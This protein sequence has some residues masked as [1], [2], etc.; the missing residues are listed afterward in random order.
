MCWVI[1]SISALASIGFEPS[2]ATQ[3]ACNDRGCAGRLKK[4]PS[5]HS[6]RVLDVIWT[7]NWSKRTLFNLVFCQTFLIYIR[8]L[9]KTFVW[10]QRDFLGKKTNS[11]LRVFCCI[12][13]LRVILFCN[14]LR[15]LS[16]LLNITNWVWFGMYIL[17]PNHV[18]SWC[19]LVWSSYL[20]SL[21]MFTFFCLI[22][23]ESL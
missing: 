7:R 16:D 5:T 3:T 10:I 6:T 14:F 15:D 11:F 23:V 19:S 1:E 8:R 22:S 18:I 17:D 4:A 2:M 12:H 20:I 9:G 21:L 13:N